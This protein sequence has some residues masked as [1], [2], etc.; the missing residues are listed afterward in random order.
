M[1][2]ELIP[3]NR[4]E[5]MSI[6][7][8][9]ALL[10]LTPRTIEQ[11]RAA[12]RLTM[13]QFGREW[14]TTLA[15]IDAACTYSNPVHVAETAKTD[16]M[17]RARRI[18]RTTTENKKASRKKR[19]AVN[20]C[21]TK[22]SKKRVRRLE[23]P[24]FS[25]GSPLQQVFLSIQ[26]HQKPLQN[27]AQNC[28]LGPRRFTKIYESSCG[29]APSSSPLAFD[30][31][32]DKTYAEVERLHPDHVFAQSQPSGRGVFEW[33]GPLSGPSRI[34]SRHRGV[35]PLDCGVVEQRSAPSRGEKNNRA[36]HRG[37]HRRLFGIQGSD[38]AET[39][40]AAIVLEL[41]RR[42]GP[43]IQPLRLAPDCRIHSEATA[44]GAGCADSRRVGTPNGERSNPQNQ[45]GVPVGSG[46]G[47]GAGECPARVGGATGSSS[48]SARDQAAQSGRRSKNDPGGDSGDR[49]DDSGSSVDRDAL[50]GIV[51]YPGV[52]HQF[53][54]GCLGLHAGGTQNEAPWVETSDLHRAESAERDATIHHR[55]QVCLQLAEVPETVSDEWL[56][57]NGPQGNQGREGRPL[58]PSPIEAPYRDGRSGGVR[59]GDRARNQR[60]QVIGRNRNLCGKECGGDHRG[61]AS[62]RL[63][64]SHL[65]KPVKLID[66]APS[67][68]DGGAA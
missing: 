10:G 8:T 39:Q 16:S 57:P 54:A 48:G 17:E 14:F 31:P 26:K 3:L 13:R 50:G 56:L 2:T 34:G 65:S 38:I 46:R 4:G 19:K 22:T 66:G 67:V 61:G 9:A 32:Y 6:K 27:I 62:D 58:A 36:D 44:I 49:G 18:L 35:Q 33:P 25:L 20:R 43:I 41:E 1:A 7:E 52:G 12:G 47:V 28:G 53:I 45:D 23:R 29:Y 24:T 63:S 40:G 11:W 37:P 59:G 30:T 51:Q 64:I 55:G 5:R 15:M 21:D 68:R 42:F 60:P